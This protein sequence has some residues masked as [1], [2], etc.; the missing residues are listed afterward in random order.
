MKTTDP[1][2]RKKCTY[3]RAH[4]KKIIYDWMALR[5]PLKL[6]SAPGSQLRARSLSRA[7]LC[8]CCSHPTLFGEKCRLL[9]HSDDSTFKQVNGHSSPKSIYPTASEPRVLGSRR[10]N[11]Q[12]HHTGTISDSKDLESHLMLTMSTQNEF[13][14]LGP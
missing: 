2:L 10:V 3:A 12:S 11:L 4:T 7:G 9:G 14:L 1:L 5:N 6:G 8:L 13:C